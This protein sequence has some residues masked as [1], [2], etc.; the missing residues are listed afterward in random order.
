MSA[1]TFF[2]F[3]VLAFVMGLFMTKGTAEE[4]H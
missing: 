2:T 3:A 4:K 1:F